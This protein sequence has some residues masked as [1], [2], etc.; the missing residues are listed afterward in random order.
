M[1]KRQFKSAKDAIDKYMADPK[2]NIKP[3][4]WYYKGRIYNSLSYDSTL[5][6]KEIYDLKLQAFEAF[7][8]N[9]QLDDKDLRMKVEQYQSYLDLYFGYYDL[10]ATQ[11]N[12][13]DYSGAYESFKK[14]LM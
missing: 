3:D 13:K 6:K 14:P 9:Q 10:G 12:A 4:G 5:S 8:K 7:Q 2:N 11:F 1:N